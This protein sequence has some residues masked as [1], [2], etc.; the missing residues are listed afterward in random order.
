MYAQLVGCANNIRGGVRCK[1][2]DPPLTFARRIAM[3]IYKIRQI[4]ID[5]N[6]ATVPLSKGLSAIIDVGDVHLVCDANWHAWASTPGKPRYA[7][8]NVRM[9]NGRQ[10]T[11][12]M[13]RIILSPSDGGHVDHINGDGLDNR[14]CNLREVTPLQNAMNRQDNSNNTSGVRGVSWSAMVQKWH[15]Q[16]WINRKRIHLG[17]HE[18]IND[19]GD[20]YIAASIKYF[21][22][23]SHLRRKKDDSF[24]HD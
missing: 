10:T 23:Y 7:M 21:G 2:I 17:F 22:E 1:R 15:A 6:V 14:R 8:R 3:A 20:A 24:V 13:H 18:D 19:A 4:K 12:K 16:I 11:V 5:G 9:P